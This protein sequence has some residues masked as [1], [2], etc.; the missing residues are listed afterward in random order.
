MTPS[1][2]VFYEYTW[3]TTDDKLS[4]EKE[5]TEFSDFSGGVGLQLDLAPEVSV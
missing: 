2:G 3:E 1:F 5:S 4:A